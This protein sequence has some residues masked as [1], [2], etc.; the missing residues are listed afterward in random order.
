MLDQVEFMGVHKERERRMGE[1]LYIMSD[2]VKF[3]GVHREK[4]KNGKGGLYIC[5][6]K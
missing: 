4:E 6:I 3:V 5:R 1:G 2:Q